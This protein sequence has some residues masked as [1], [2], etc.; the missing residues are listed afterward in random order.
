M[1]RRTKLITLIVV[2]VI[3]LTF[4]LTVLCA[5]ETGESYSF[6]GIRYRVDLKTS[7][8]RV[9]GFYGGEYDELYVCEV[10][11]FVEYYG[12]R[13]PVVELRAERYFM[14]SSPNIIESGKIKTLIVPETVTSI[15][16]DGFNY[17]SLSALES[18]VVHPNNSV[19]KSIDGI[20]YNVDGTE[21]LY[22]P[23]NIQLDVLQIRRE[24]AVISEQANFSFAKFGDVSVEEG[25]V[26]YKSVD[27]ALYTYDGT[28]LLHY[29]HTKQDVSFTVGKEVAAISCP[30]YNPNLQ[31]IDVD[32]NNV[33]FKSI[34]GILYDEFDVLL[35]YP[36]GRQA[37]SFVVPATTSCI[38]S[39]ALNQ[40]IEA[41]TS[42]FIP[43]TVGS[44]EYRAILADITIFTDAYSV[45]DT[46]ELYGN[47]KNNVKVGVSLEQ[48]HE[49]T[50]LT[51]EGES[52]E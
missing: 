37:S 33:M 19:Y 8:A 46:W 47:Q 48:Y 22:C 12:V 35:C 18:I 7:T 45:P 52:A 44:I 31:H 28:N 36:M 49:R 39:G 30:L 51:D 15:E 16:L 40:D 21:M 23:E 6:E 32:E 25:N 20:L 42:I 11:A 3:C 27:G 17:S 41:L 5:C 9:V 4:A 2:S 24:L 34:D 1:K 10:P 50:Q 26:L 43:S 14:A 13:Y 29:S 38:K